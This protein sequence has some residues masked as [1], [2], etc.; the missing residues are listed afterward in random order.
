MR[1]GLFGGTFNPIHFGH[2]R[3]AE[4]VREA[5]RLDEV[6]FVPSAT[7]PHK[8]PAR[9]AT[10]E[11]RYA[12]VR[13]AVAGQPQLRVSRIEIDRGG[14]SFSVDTLATLRQRYPEHRFSFLLGLDAFMDI[15]TW[16]DYPRLF[17]LCDIVVTSRPPHTDVDLLAAIPVVARGQFCYA[18]ARNRLRHAS[19]HRVIFQR[20]SDLAISATA[21]RDLRRRG[22]SIRF[23]VPPAVERYIEEKRLY[24]RRTNTP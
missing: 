16:K 22:R 8:S 5:Q 19:G 2:L 3:S 21:I 23:L 20:I 4:E 11:H 14:R 12:M 10:A 15:G 7:P 13:R 17:T 9:L 1:I 6:W 24:T 18:R